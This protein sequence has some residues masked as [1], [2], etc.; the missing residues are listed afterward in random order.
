MGSTWDL[1][2]YT[3]HSVVFIGG[4]TTLSPHVT[5]T[6]YIVGCRTVS[7]PI[8]NIF[9]NFI[10]PLHPCLYGLPFFK[11]G[12]SNFS[13]NRDPLLAGIYIDATLYY[14][15]REFCDKL[16]E[17]IILMFDFLLKNFGVFKFSL[18]GNFSGF[19]GAHEKRRS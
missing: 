2:L 10:S 12:V 3:Q 4:S 15:K 8:I 11:E 7:L 14:G 1:R 5:T 13:L 19:V 6:S 9:G 16:P 17:L 18:S